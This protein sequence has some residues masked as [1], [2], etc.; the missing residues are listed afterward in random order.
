[1]SKEQCIQI[2]NNFKKILD[3]NESILKKIKEPDENDIQLIKEKFKYDVSIENEAKSLF[4]IIYYIN[5][6]KN[7][8]LDNKSRLEIEYEIFKTP[9]FSS[10]YKKMYEYTKIEQMFK[11][12]LNNE[13]VT[14][15][16]LIKI[17][18]DIENMK[19]LKKKET[20]F[21]PADD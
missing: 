1:M 5:A 11:K 15:D 19:K 18:N 9:R 20:G 14:D 12:L 2:I 10:N 3:D 21:K 17:L 8:P 13:N 16:E 6:I 7:Y 4:I